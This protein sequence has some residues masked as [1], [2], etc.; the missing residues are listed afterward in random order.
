MRIYILLTLLGTLAKESTSFGINWDF[1]EASDVDYESTVECASPLIAVDGLCKECSAGTYI[2][3]SDCIDCPIGTYTDTVSQTSC[4]A[5]GGGTSTM[6]IGS[7]ASSDCIA[8]CT[9]PTATF[10]SGMYP[11]AG[12][13]V[14]T[15]T[16][17]T[18][19]CQN[20][21]YIDGQSTK[22]EACSTTPTSCSK[23]T[24]TIGQSG[25]FTAGSNVQL[26]CTVVTGDTPT[27]NDHSKCSWTKEGSSIANSGGASFSAHTT[28][29]NTYECVQTL[30]GVTSSSAG[31]YACSAVIASRTESAICIPTATLNVLTLTYDTAQVVDILGV[32][33]QLTCTA[34][35]PTPLSAI[36]TFEWER[37]GTL[38]TS[39]VVSDTY[40]TT[41][42]SVL[43]LSPLA[44][45]DT[46][47]YKC[48][49]TYSNIGV[50]ESS[51]KQV[52][53]VYI[54]T[55]IP[56]RQA[57]AGTSIT[58]TCI[59]YGTAQTITWTTPQGSNGGSQTSS[60][61][62]DGV[63]T[64]TNELVLA[65]VES[66]THDGAYTCVVVNA[67]K[68]VTSSGNLN[69]YV[70]G[71][72][73]TQSD[74]VG[75]VGSDIVLTLN[76]DTYGPDATKFKSIA[77][78]HDGNGIHSG[79]EYKITAIEYKITYSIWNGMIAKSTSPQFVSIKGSNGAE[80]L[81]ICVMQT[82]M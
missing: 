82:S 29:A 54:A 43:T 13:N 64:L 72:R 41:R 38:V 44:S 25:Y 4:T 19:F 63:K 36:L 40:G 18:T 31:I 6:S 79:V 37:D 1:D 3:T 45:T 7:T 27:L 8:V 9:V 35:M 46:A 53:A 10:S 80:Q 33:I 77:W 26:T 48:F 17:I 16:T 50:L 59:T 73:S 22:T 78:Y 42:D 61:T 67:G 39:G 57:V 66:A 75:V 47:K 2:G 62:T 5:C 51:E 71:W 74:I 60:S 65:N 30:S 76:A 49:A 24:T 32:S 68:T 81:N 11:L 70:D 34:T 52:V 20:E 28:A 15:G 14:A 58:L 69:V 55:P 21:Y 23:V 56:N 12:T